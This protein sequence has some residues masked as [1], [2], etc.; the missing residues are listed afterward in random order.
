MIDLDWIYSGRRPVQTF[1]ISNTYP[2]TAKLTS[3][4][5][6]IY[7]QIYRSYSSAYNNSSC[8]TSTSHTFFPSNLRVDYGS[9][10]DYYDSE[11][12]YHHQSYAID[13]GA[14]RSSDSTTPTTA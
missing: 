6:D 10:S 3:F 13:V 8:Q 2:P 4:H 12:H 14:E 5:P 9:G 1:P 11:H 7:A